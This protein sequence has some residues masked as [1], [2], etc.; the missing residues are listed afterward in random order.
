M[1][2]NWAAMMVVLKAAS[3]VMQTVVWKAGRLELQEAV[4]RAEHSGAQTVVSTEFLSVALMDGLWDCRSVVWKD[5]LVADCW[6]SRWGDKTVARWVANWASQMVDLLVD[7]KVVHWDD[8]VAES[9]AGHSVLTR[10]VTMAGTWDL[11]KGHNWAAQLVDLMVDVKEERLVDWRTVPQ[12]VRS[13]DVRGGRL[14][15]NLELRMV[16]ELAGLM[17][18]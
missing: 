14:A 5:S 2:K 1:D 9:S 4:V 12:A 15:D 17:V 8:I 7:P 6:E 13:D 18:A 11:S 10:D 3:W 16:E